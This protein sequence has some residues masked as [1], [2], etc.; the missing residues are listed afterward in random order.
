MDST[1]LG[2]GLPFAIVSQYL[3]KIVGQKLTLN[4]QT[5]SDN[6]CLDNIDM[7]KNHHKCVPRGFSQRFRVLNTVRNSSDPIFFRIVTS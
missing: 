3:K 6:G 1:A 2:I 7:V 5:A 4:P